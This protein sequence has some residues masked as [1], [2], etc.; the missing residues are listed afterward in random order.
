[1]MHLKGYIFLYI[2]P[3]KLLLD[4]DSKSNLNLKGKQV[5]KRIRNIGW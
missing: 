4:T 2:Y 1:M 3:F 5:N